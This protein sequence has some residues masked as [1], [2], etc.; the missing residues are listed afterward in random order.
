MTPADV[1]DKTSGGVAAMTSFYDPAVRIRRANAAE[2][3]TKSGASFM[4][5]TA[6][7]RRPGARALQRAVAAALPARRAWAAFETLEPRQMLTVSITG[8]VTLDESTGLQTSG[9]A[10]PGE[11][12]NDN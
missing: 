5:T 8:S 2:A 6:R 3:T 7:T 4:S 9:I 10:V 12:N 11:D 1:P